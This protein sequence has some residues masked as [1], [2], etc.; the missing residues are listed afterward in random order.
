MI[1]DLS[2]TKKYFREKLKDYKKMPIVP[3]L[4]SPRDTRKSSPS[5]DV[6]IADQSVIKRIFE[7]VVQGNREKARSILSY[8]GL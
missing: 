7:A 8:S 4:F 2:E 1:Q 3:I 6:F 5:I